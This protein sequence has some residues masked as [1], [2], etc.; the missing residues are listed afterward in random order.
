MCHPGRVRLRA[1][2]GF[3]RT[4]GVGKCLGEHARCLGSQRD[5]PSRGQAANVGLGI[6]GEAD[7]PYLDRNGE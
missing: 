6:E 2:I 4:H 5:G 7:A 1:P 3:S